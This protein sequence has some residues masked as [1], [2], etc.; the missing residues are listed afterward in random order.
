MVI[1]ISVLPPFTYPSLS[2]HGHGVIIVLCD[3][4]IFS[5]PINGNVTRVP[6]T[7]MLKTETFSAIYHRLDASSAEVTFG[8]IHCAESSPS[9]LASP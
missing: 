7:A 9:D 3:L 4:Q 6:C 2:L 1:I 8:T 5:Y